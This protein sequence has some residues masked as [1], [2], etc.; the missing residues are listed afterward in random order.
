MG[1]GSYLGM[2]IWFNLSHLLEGQMQ[3]IVVT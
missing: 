3:M 2:V 1:Q